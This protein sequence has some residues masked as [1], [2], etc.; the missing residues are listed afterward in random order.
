MFGSKNIANIPS[1]FANGWVALNFP[2]V[3]TGTRH[4]L[5]GGASTT[6]NTATGT[7]GS[8]AATTF[9][10]LPTIGFAAQTFVNG[11]L[12]NSGVSV[13]SNYGGNFAHKFTRLIQ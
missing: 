7:Q 3:S 10:G 8:L 1:S 13:Q 6:F 5:I 4:I 9:N 12:I 2:L 11:T